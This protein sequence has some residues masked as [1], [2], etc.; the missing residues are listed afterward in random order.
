MHLS[1]VADL[2]QEKAHFRPG[3]G[4][5]QWWTGTCL[6]KQELPVDSL[7]NSHTPDSGPDWD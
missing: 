6:D 7:I 5:R 3:A 1:A 4:F 2:L